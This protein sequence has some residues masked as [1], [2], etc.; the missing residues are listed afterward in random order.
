MAVLPRLD[1]GIEIEE[2]FFPRKS[3]RETSVPS[4]AIRAND[5]VASP[6]L[7]II[8]TCRHHSATFGAESQIQV[9]EYLKIRPRGHLPFIRV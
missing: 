5:G 8:I 4:S 7:S 2:T 9:N 1:L 6:T 3:A